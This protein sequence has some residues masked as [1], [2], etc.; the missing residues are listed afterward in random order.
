MIPT[1]LVLHADK[2]TGGK[3]VA[4]RSTDGEFWVAFMNGAHMTYFPKPDQD[5]ARH[6]PVLSEDRLSLSIVEGNVQLTWR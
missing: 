1:S 4:F 3:H 6:R 5:T 2:R